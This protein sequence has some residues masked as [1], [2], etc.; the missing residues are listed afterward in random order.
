LRHIANRELTIAESATLAALPQIPTVYLNNPDRLKARRDWILES[1]AEL[2]FIT[3]EELSAALAEETPVN[4][5]VSGIEAPHFVFWVKEQLVEEYGERVVEQGGLNVITTLDFEKQQAAED[6]VAQNIEARS[7]VY[8][9]NNTS[10]ISLDSKTGEVLAMVGSADFFDDEIDGQVNTTLRPLQPGS[11]FKPIIYAAGFERGY[12][13]NTILWDAVTT[14]PTQTGAYTPQNF[15]FN[16]YGPM[17]VRASLQGSLNIPAVKMLYLIGVESGIQ[18]AQKLGYTTINDP[19]RV[20]LSLV[21]GGGEVTPLEHASAYATFANDGRYRETVSI[22]KVENAAGDILEETTIEGD[23]ERVI[24]ANVARMLSNV[25]SDDGARAYIF[26]T[27]SFLTLPGRPV[28]AKTGT[29]NNSKDAWT[30]GYTPQITTAVWTGNTD[31]RNMRASA[32]GSTVAAPVWNAYMRA[33]HEGLP[34][35]SFAN[36]SIPSTG[37]PVLDGVLPFETVRVDT[38]SGKLATERTP[39]HLIEEKVCGEYRSILSYVDRSNPAGPVP[40]NPESDPHFNAWQN[41]I[42]RLVEESQSRPETED[43]GRESRVYEICDIPTEED[44]VHTAQNEPRI[45]IRSPRRNDDIAG[46]V[47][48]EYEA[49][50]RRGV[51][52][53]EVRMN[54]SIIY[55]E[56][57]NPGSLTV[58]IPSYIREGRAELTIAAFD[59][60]DNEG[61]DSVSVNVTSTIGQRSL[62]I[63][64]PVSG[65]RFRAG[66][67]IEINS[68]NP[69]EL[70]TLSIEVVNARTG[71]VVFANEVS[72]PSTIERFTWTPEANGLYLIRAYGKAGNS[73]TSAAPVE[74]IITSGPVRDS[75]NL[76]EETTDEIENELIAE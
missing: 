39:E 48:I 64:S 10:L 58:A 40:N 46:S 28:A 15:N 20:G 41:A 24:D 76:L 6:A 68:E 67:V 75:F 14:F 16:E 27:G 74:I 70:D 21:L 73:E 4:I 44:D 57:G 72:S 61:T 35:E 42:N 54:G 1:M 26:G 38:F 11:S 53:I 66:D 19:S 50:A 49:S 34:V 32:G 65:E 71:G 47:E 51:A 45:A 33:A 5:R 37:K 7:E 30:V 55:A 2:D 12:T 13:P 22:L 29:T 43:G 63:T 3:E 36:P 52:R 62:R 31:G 17:T 69:L 59:D 9:F 18:F 25:L 56:Q 23:G 8:G 60:A